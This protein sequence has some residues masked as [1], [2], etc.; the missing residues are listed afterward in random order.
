MGQEVGHSL[1]QLGHR[2]PDRVTHKTVVV[3][4]TRHLRH[5]R[6][7]SMAFSSLSNKNYACTHAYIRLQ[8]GQSPVHSLPPSRIY[9]AYI[10]IYLFTCPVPYTISLLKP[11]SRHFMP[12][13]SSWILLVCVRVQTVSV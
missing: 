6:K 2:L 4:F 3:I 10:V 13:S 11:R 12:A 5:R 9:R 8:P 7:Q 1:T